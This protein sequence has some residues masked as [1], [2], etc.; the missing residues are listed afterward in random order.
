MGGENRVLGQI[1]EDSE[2]LRV[3]LFRFSVLCH[4]GSRLLALGWPLAMSQK[5]HLSHCVGSPLALVG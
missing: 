4:Q 1:K 5:D 3:E 2:C